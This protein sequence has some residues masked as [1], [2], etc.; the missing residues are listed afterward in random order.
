MFLSIDT[1]LRQAIK[2]L[3]LDHTLYELLSKPIR[4]T[5]V[6]FP[7]VMDDGDIRVFEGYRVIHSN[8]LGPSKGGIRYSEALNLELVTALSTWMTLKCAIV[9]LPYGGAKGGVKCN[10]KHLSQGELERVTRAYTRS[11]S[12]LIGPEKDIPAP[13]MGTSARQMGWIVDEYSRIVG[14]REPAVVTGKPLI[15]SGSLGRV[16]ATGRGVMIVALE[17]MKQ[18]DMV[19]KKA[20]VAVYGFGNVGRYAA[21]FLQ[22][23]GC[24]VVGISDRTGAYFNLNGIDVQQAISY[25]E[26]QKTLQGLPSTKPMSL[27]QFI[28]LKVDVL[29]LA[30]MENA[31]TGQNAHDVQ[32]KLI[33]E[34]AN[35]ATDLEAD[36][37]LKE[38]NILVVPDILASAGGVI[39]SYYEWI[40]NRVGQ[41]WLLEQVRENLDKTMQDAFKR[42]YKTSQKSKASLRLASYI[43]AVQKLSEAYSYKGN[44]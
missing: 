28:S 10:P 12:E 37:I 26:C 24:R 14:K 5:T 39:S 35:G 2:F 9:P 22:E 40:Q 31:I 15:F 43:E 18:M 1:Q 32:A 38:K 8:L 36:N 44:Y 30:A 16:E 6:C 13:D 7:V 3:Q 21:K 29:I 27:Q 11:I 4:Q 25:K 17:A 41:S 34:G 42:V 20:S 33:V 23:K 19:N